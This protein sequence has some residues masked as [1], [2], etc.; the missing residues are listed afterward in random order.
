MQLWCFI[1]SS[2]AHRLDLRPRKILDQKLNVVFS[3]PSSKGSFI[4]VVLDAQKPFFKKIVLK[5]KKVISV[6]HKFC[7]K[8]EC[9]KSV[10]SLSSNRASLQCTGGLIL[11]CVLIQTKKGVITRLSYAE[12]DRINLQLLRPH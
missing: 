4:L 9:Q 11:P 3:F 5:F 2:Q 10:F 6:P 8:I 12:W 7:V 1:R